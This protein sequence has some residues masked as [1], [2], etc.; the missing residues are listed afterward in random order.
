MKTHPSKISTLIVIAVLLWIIGLPLIQMYFN[1]AHLNWVNI[2]FILVTLLIVCYFFFTTRYIIDKDK[3]IIKAGFFRMKT[4]SI[5]TI[6]KVVSSKSIAS[7][8][9]ASLDRLLIKFGKYDEV[10][11]SPRNKVAFVKD[12]RDVNSCI[13]V[14]LD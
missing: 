6:T 12:L 7:A 8:P 9:A 5:P 3:L 10:L 4:V 14:E 1:D 13:T 2:T 11:V